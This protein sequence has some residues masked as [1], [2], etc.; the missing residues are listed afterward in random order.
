MRILVINWQ[1]IKNPLGGG[2][3]VHLFELFS[4]ISKWGHNVTLLCSRFKGAKRKEIV[5]GIRVIRCGTRGSFNFFVPFAYYALCKNL[6]FDVVVEDI[7][8]IPFYC[9]LFIKKPLLGIIHHL[10][11]KTIYKEVAFPAAT[12]VYLSERLIPFFYRNIPFTVVSQSSKQELL[13]MGMRG[14]NLT[15]IHNCVDHQ[16]YRPSGLTKFDIPTVAFVGRLKKY[17]SID[18]LIKAM[19]IVA[20]E[21]DRVKLLIIGDGDYRNQLQRLTTKLGLD[22]I[23][24]FTGYVEEGR[25]VE[26]L[27]RSHVVVNPSPKEGWGLTNIEANACGTP[28]IASDAPGLRDSVINGQTGLLFEYGNIRDL[29]E[30]I[31]LILGN[32]ELREKFSKGAL[33]WASGFSWDASAAEMLNLLNQIVNKSRVLS[34]IQN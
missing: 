29:A 4:R 15:V 30:K 32:R 31:L 13:R 27:E 12:Y 23:V 33:S 8:K 11:G 28:V 24:E 2:A 26:L 9:P 19:Q 14:E 22:S 18:I 20:G 6:Q 1:D 3:E 34:T 17:K 7:N 25:K 10:F 21:I 16:L 5:Q